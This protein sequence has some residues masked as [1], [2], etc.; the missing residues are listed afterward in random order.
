[1][2]RKKLRAKTRDDKGT[3]LSTEKQAVHSSLQRARIPRR[4]LA[5]GRA[6]GGALLLDVRPEV[7]LDEDHAGRA[8]LRGELGRQREGRARPRRGAEGHGATRGGERRRRDRDARR[9]R[10]RY[11]LDVG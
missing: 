5:E 3:L 11:G 8:R 1:M 2:R 7:L 4:D 9:N 6:Q 10:G